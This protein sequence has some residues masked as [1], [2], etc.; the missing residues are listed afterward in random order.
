[1]GWRLGALALASLADL[2]F[3]LVWARARVFVELVVLSFAPQR[4]RVLSVLR[5]QSSPSGCT[6]WAELS[7]LAAIEVARRP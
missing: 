5:S 2:V 4:K 3:E 7:V 6:S 1:M